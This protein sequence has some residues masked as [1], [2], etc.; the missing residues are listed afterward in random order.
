MP[1]LWKVGRD[2]ISDHLAELPNVAAIVAD[3]GYRGWANLA[4]RK[5]LGL[6]IKA[7]PQGT[8][9]FTPLA[10]LNKVEHAFARLGRWKRLSRC[11][12][13]TE[14]SARAWLEVVCVAYLFVR[15]RAEPT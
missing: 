9:G 11:C 5:H 13:G 2:L 14:A 15:P 8:K 12:E 7:P 6:D 1:G 3:R 10:P 4:A